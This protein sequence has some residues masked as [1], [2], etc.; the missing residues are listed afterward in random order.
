MSV[1]VCDADYRPP[2]G[3]DRSNPC[4]SERVDQE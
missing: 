2:F 1:C 3:S 4:A